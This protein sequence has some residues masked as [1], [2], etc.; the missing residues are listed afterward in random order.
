MALND[1][2]LGGMNQTE[3][4]AHTSKVGLYDARATRRTLELAFP[5]LGH[6]GMFYDFQSKRWIVAHRDKEH[7]HTTPAAAVIGLTT[8][9]RDLFSGKIPLEE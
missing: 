4:R 6:V 5:P 2:A 9:V 7:A 8:I 3:R 1:Y